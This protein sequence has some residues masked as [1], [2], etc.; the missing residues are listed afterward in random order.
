[1]SSGLGEGRGRGPRPI[2]EDDVK[3]RDSQAPAKV[4]PGAI[5]VSGTAGGPNLRTGAVGAIRG[6]I[7][8]LQDEP[9]DPL[10]TQPVPAPYR[11]HTREYFD[12]IRES[13]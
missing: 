2:A 1:M 3:F 11:E 4:G 6:E 12:G 8:R 5:V 9:I 10:A 13:N 7:Q